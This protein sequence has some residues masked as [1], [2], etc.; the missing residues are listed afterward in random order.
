MT[1]YKNDL[2]DNPMTREAVKSLSPEQIEDYKKIGQ[3]LYGTVDFVDSKLI[4]SLPPPL[5]ESCE[6]ITAGLNSGLH[7]SDLT[8]VEINIM[9]ESHGEKWYEKF[10][11]TIE[12]LP[13]K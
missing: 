7:P 3:Y 8:P 9:K 10:N 4:D 2:F 13:K 11:Y 12:D 5:K 1:E 6:Y